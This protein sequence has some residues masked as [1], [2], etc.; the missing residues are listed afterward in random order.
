M[1]LF[2]VGIIYGVVMHKEFITGYIY[3]GLKMVILHFLLC[4]LLTSTLCKI[5]A[6]KYMRKEEKKAVHSTLNTIEPMYAFD[7]HCNS[8][9]PFFVIAYVLQVISSSF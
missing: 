2:V 1:M 9:F 8:F 3:L 7:I 6:E 5:I 4:G